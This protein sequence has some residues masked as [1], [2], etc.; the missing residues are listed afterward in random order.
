MDEKIK[1]YNET[2][3]FGRYRLDNEKEYYRNY[4]DRYFRS[5]QL[6]IG[7]KYLPRH[8]GRPRE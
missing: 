7:T 2:F 6:F 5:T 4:L 8:S 3:E 1:Q